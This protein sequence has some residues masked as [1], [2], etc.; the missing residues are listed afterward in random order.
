MTL[1]QG[2]N[3]LP[4]PKGWLFL[5]RFAKATHIRPVISIRDAETNHHKKAGIPLFPRDRQLRDGLFNRNRN[6]G[7]IVLPGG[8][9][10]NSRFLIKALSLALGLICSARELL[11]RAKVSFSPEGV[12]NAIVTAFSVA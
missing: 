7:V 11:S 4:E 3:L 10:G 1:L 5:L 9:G 8:S 12:I 2:I 6:P